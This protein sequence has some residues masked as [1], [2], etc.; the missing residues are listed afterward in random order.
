LRQGKYSLPGHNKW[1][2]LYSLSNK[3]VKISLDRQ[4]KMYTPSKAIVNTVSNIKT[5]VTFYFIL[6]N[7][8]SGGIF[9]I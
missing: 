8:L 2:N 1:G 7:I 5:P 6:H 3:S 9:L 4:Q